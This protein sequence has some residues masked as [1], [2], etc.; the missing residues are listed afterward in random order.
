MQAEEQ[1]ADEAEQAGA[2]RPP[3]YR[4]PANRAFGGVCGGLADYLNLDA[5]LI[6]VL[7]I[8]LTIG[9]AGAG[10][11]AY[12][13]LWLLLPVGT[14]HTGM[15]EPAAM[16]LNQRNMRRAGL[17]LISLGGLWLLANVGILP[18][19]WS[20]FWRTV[21]LV[22]WPV[23]LIAAGMLLL[24]NQK[25]WR[26][27]LSAWGERLG[28]RAGFDDLSQRVKSVNL[29]GLR[30]DGSKVRSGLGNLRQRI[31]LKRSRDERVVLGVCGGMAQAMKVDA[32][33]VRLFWVLFSVGSVGTGA[34]VY[35]LLALILPERNHEP[36]VISHMER[37][38]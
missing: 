17:L 23:V 6:R 32:N 13:A 9:S 3:L 21:G 10:F 30:P 35:A 25:E 36:R 2:S 18:W 29:N 19:L 22:F 5:G 8:V 16:A 7:W 11:L 20:A 26:A 24:K 14:V 4:H 27:D 31:P 34:V 12:M 37:P 38:M 15:Q 33:L 28:N 1:G